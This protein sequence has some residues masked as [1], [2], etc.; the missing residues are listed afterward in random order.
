MIRQ[1]LLP[2]IYPTLYALYVLHNAEENEAYK[3]RI[4]RLNRQCDFA[5]LSFLG[6]DENFH[7]LD[8]DCGDAESTV[9]TKVHW[10]VWLDHCGLKLCVFFL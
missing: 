7:F 3:S 10:S 8:D 1:F 5:L 4:T 2:R 6:V 9:A